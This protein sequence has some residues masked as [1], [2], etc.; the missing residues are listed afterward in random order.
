MIR[1]KYGECGAEDDNAGIV[2]PINEYEGDDICDSDV[3]KAKI[4][5]SK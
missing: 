3:Y 5:V 1:E 4:I 2:E